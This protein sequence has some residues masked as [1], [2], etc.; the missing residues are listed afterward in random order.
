MKYSKEYAEKVLAATDIVSVISNY[1]PLKQNNDQYVGK[2]PFDKKKIQSLVVFPDSQT[3]HCFEC[4]EG[5]NTAV[6]LMKKEGISFDEALERLA[7]QAHITPT[8]ADLREPKDLVV[9]NNLQKAY[10]DAA[11]FYIN[12]L[13]SP[14]GKDGMSYLKARKLD[15]KTIKNWGLG[16]APAKGNMLSKYMKNLGYSDDLLL[17]AGLIKVSETGPYDFFRNR[18]MFPIVNADNIVVAFSGRVLDDAKPKYLNSPESIIFNKGCTFFGMNKAGKY[19]EKNNR[20][21]ICEGQ[22]DVIRLH[23]AG[24]KEAIAP[25]GTAMTH[26]HVPFIVEKAQ[27]II[28][29]TDSDAAGQKAV[30]RA[31]KN[32]S[33]SNVNI[34]ILDMSPHKDPDEFITIEGPEAYQERIKEARSSDDFVL[35]YLSQKYDMSDPEQKEKYLQDAV[36]TIIDL[37]DRKERIK[38][39]RMERDRN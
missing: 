28:I 13:N 34:R 23:Q 5:G 20:C 11:I 3:F 19:M 8:E 9:I 12:K 37:N 15:D 14:D 38:E 26:A 35:Q 36:N 32:L 10:R 7:V 1:V 39:S 25:M 21:L 27:N 29:T 33:S 24:F 18:V 30:M 31:I 22:M 2:C 4:G 16:F 6:F 17:Q